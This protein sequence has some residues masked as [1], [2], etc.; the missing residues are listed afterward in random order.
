MNFERIADKYPAEREALD[1]LE[2]LL[3]QGSASRP[4]Y[5]FGFLCDLLRPRSR[6]GLALVLA[7]LVHA[8]RLKRVV[9]VVSPT[10]QG[11]LGDFDGIEAVPAHL[12]DWR[13]DLQIEVRPEDL[14]IIYILQSPEGL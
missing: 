12:H 4:E 11:G 13:A 6:E 5:T 2:R 1:R 9:R 3:E 14:R 8:G 10:T 7:E